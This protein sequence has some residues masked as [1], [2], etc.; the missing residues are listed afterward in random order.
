MICILSLILYS[1]LVGTK[2]GRNARAFAFHVLSEMVSKSVETVVNPP[3]FTI[4]LLRQ[5][6]YALTRSVSRLG[7]VARSLQCSSRFYHDLV[8]DHYE[9]PR[10]VGRAQ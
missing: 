1:L 10:N 5:I 4:T 6:M 9:H 2:Q 8:I 3:F 7:V